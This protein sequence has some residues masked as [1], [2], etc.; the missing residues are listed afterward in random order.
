MSLVG[1]EGAAG[2]AA[3]ALSCSAIVVLHSPGRQP[4]RSSS[5]VQA[6]RLCLLRQDLRLSGHLNAPPTPLPHSLR[7][8]EAGKRQKGPSRVPLSC[9]ET[10]LTCTAVCWGG[11]GE[12]E[13]PKGM[14]GVGGVGLEGRGRFVHY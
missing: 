5:K 8:R 9:V 4:S 11:G 6:T 1:A 10:V 12:G 3:A 14:Q 13:K 7:C 2:R